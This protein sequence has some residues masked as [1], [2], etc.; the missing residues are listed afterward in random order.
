MHRNVALIRVKTLHS[1]VNF[2]RTVYSICR[3]N[4]KCFEC[5]NTFE[6]VFQ[7]LL[8]KYSKRDPNYNKQ[9]ILQV[10]HSNHWISEDYVQSK[11]KGCHDTDSLLR[12]N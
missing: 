6:L 5:T 7:L 8:P 1:D 3:V 10:T 12:Y 2:V 9:N 11:P 4:N